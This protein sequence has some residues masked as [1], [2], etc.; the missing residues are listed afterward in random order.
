MKD[1]RAKVMLLTCEESCSECNILATT[2]DILR[3][4]SK[5]AICN[6]TMKRGTRIGVSRDRLCDAVRV[7]GLLYN[8]NL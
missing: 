4:L 8:C 6:L 5:I 2:N 7:I 3:S 1:Y